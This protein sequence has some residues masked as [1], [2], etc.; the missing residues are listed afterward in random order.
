MQENQYNALK[1]NN[2]K[3]KNELIAKKKINSYLLDDS[4]PISTGDHSFAELLIENPTIITNPSIEAHKNNSYKI[5]QEA[6]TELSKVLLVNATP[7][8]EIRRFKPTKKIISHSNKESR[9]V[10]KHGN[11]IIQNRQNSTGKTMNVTKKNST[12]RIANDWF[13]DDEAFRF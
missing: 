5:D 2:L 3:R 13:E 12:K 9:N 4:S 10:S 8:K 11:S 6:A 7:D 1:E